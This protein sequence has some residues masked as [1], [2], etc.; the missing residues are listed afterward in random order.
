MNRPLLRVVDII[1]ATVGLVVLSPVFVIVL[2][3][4][5]LDG[6]S[7]F[8]CQRRLG[9]NQKQFT[10]YKFRSMKVG[11]TS[12]P[13]HLVDGKQITK[14]GLWLRKTKLDELPQLWNVL[15]GEMSLV[16]PRPNLPQ[17]HAIIHERDKRQVYSVRPGVTGLAQLKSID[18]SNPK[19]LA[20][21]DAEMVRTLTL[22]R[23]FFYIALTIVGKGSG[24]KTQ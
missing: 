16:G 3:A 6:G 9:L 1:G 14:L 17:Q 23:Y 4:V 15:C 13:T 19:L 24:D 21:S 20:E 18:M 22:K 12:M 8:F 7:P 11:T 10:M 5:Y 2:L